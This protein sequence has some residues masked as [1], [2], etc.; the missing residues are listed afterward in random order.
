MEVTPEKVKAKRRNLQKQE[1]LVSALWEFA[2]DLQKR[3]NEGQII[4]ASN[5]TRVSSKHINKAI[6][7]IMETFGYAVTEIQ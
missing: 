6:A 1:K 2:D 4:T 5:G 3:P 7:D